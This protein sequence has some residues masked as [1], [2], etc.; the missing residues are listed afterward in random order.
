MYKTHNCGE[1]RD[2]HA[3]QRVTLAGWVHRRRD[4][5]GVIFLDL[6]DR[7]GVI[8]VTVNP[9]LS[10]ETL[11]TVANVRMEWV[12][13]VTGTVQKRPTGMQNPRMQTGEVEVIA[14]SIEVLNPAKTLPFMVSAENDLPDENMR[15]RYRYLDLRRNAVWNV[16]EYL[17]FRG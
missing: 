16:R 17:V 11:D 1:L 15:L 7:Y 13:Q 10:K 2:I 9:N 14:E 8:Q 3:A 6:R 4:H 5:G 12:L